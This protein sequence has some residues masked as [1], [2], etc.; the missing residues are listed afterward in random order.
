MSNT[1]RS[2]ASD[3]ADTVASAS[4]GVVRVDARRR[5]PASGIVWSADGV[6]VTANHV[7][8]RDEDIQVGLA[9]GRSVPAALVG[10]DPGTDLAVLRAQAGELT[11]PTWSAADTLRVGELVL[12]IGRP[13]ESAET[14]LGVVNAVGGHWLTGTGARVEPF[15][16]ASVEMLPGFSGGPVVNADGHIVGLATSGLDRAGAVILP[17]ATVRRAVDELLA[18]GRVRRGYLGVTANPV[19]LPEGLGDAGQDVGLMLVAVEPGSPAAS[20]GLMLGDVIVALDGKPVR[21]ME[22]L[23]ARLT[24]DLIGQTVAVRVLRS[25][26]PQDVKVVVGERPAQD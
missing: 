5:L 7:V 8:R 18:H 12:A 24:S 25:G 2:L 22:G 19:R 17:E 20:A 10:R 21:R 15:V 9:D 14:S 13:G 1:F 4:A 16:R 3:L 11:L 26:Q 23:L 6:I